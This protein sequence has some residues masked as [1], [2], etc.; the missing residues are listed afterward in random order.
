MVVDYLIIGQG[1]SGTFLSYY[2][3]KENKSVLVID[4]NRQ[5]S[6]SR[7]AAGIINPVTGRR[8][9]TVWLAD[10]ILPYAWKAYNEIGTGLDVTTIAQKTIID[11]FPNPFMRES[12]L[13]RIEEEFPYVHAYPEQNDFNPYFNYAFGCGEIRPTYAVFLENLLPA[14]RKK[15]QDDA[16]LIE[17]TFDSSLLTTSNESIRYKDITASAI[18]FC[19]GAGGFDNPYFQQL[20][21]AP[22]KGEAIIVAIPGLPSTHIFKKS[23][24][25]VPLA[26]EDLFWI[27]S[28]YQ[29][30]FSDPYPTKAFME[31]AVSTLT[32]WIKPSFKILE[33]RAA[34]RPATIERRPFVGMHPSF[35][36]IGILNG[37]GTK[38]CSLAPY[39][40]KQ[41]CDHLIYHMDI[42][43]EADVK[44]FARILSR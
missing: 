34:V 12:F 16:Q 1:I 28:T 15:L 25:L 27:G 24:S 26:Q 22:N 7:I 44:R 3:K 32:E 13:R 35:N 6:P 10:E 31:Q 40:A 30:E 18:I 42:T 17:E 39:F 14:W 4:D 11:F 20:P 29:W 23:M 8:L 33:H 9:V 38:G 36:N 41:L 37:M 21:F 5:D 2:L 43:P 19:D